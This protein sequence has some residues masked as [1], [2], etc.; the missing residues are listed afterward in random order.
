MQ[1]NQRSNVRLH[2]KGEYQVGR[3]N[4]FIV[5]EEKP[6]WRHE[7]QKTFGKALGVAEHCAKNSV[8]ETCFVGTLSEGAWR[9]EVGLV[10]RFTTRSRRPFWLELWLELMCRE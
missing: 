1:T 2:W 4:S 10:D 5:V 6:V 7:Q 3:R 8:Y 9:R